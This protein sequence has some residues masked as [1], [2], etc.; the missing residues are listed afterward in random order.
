M[1]YALQHLQIEYPSLF[2]WQFF[3][4]ASL[5]IAEFLSSEDH[6]N[7]TYKRHLLTGAKVAHMLRH[8]VKC[9]CEMCCFF[10]RV[11]W[12]RM[13]SGKGFK[14]IQRTIQWC[15][16][17]TTC[18]VSSYSCFWLPKKNAGCLQLIIKIFKDCLKTSFGNWNSACQTLCT[19]KKR[20]SS[21]R[22]IF[23]IV[24]RA[25]VPCFENHVIDKTLFF[26]S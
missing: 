15:S 20:C 11:W 13:Q 18:G 7:K 3:V 6:S 8:L 23:G 12:H 2:V 26:F 25:V 4:S 9:T 5:G 1:Q 24:E 22:H 21:A 16:S 19:K 10:G 14:K 17:W